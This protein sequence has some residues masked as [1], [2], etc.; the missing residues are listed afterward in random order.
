MQKCRDF[1]KECEGPFLRRPIWAVISAE[2]PPRSP[3]PPKKNPMEFHERKS[4]LAPQLM[5]KPCVK[6]MLEPHS[7][8]KF[9]CTVHTSS[10]RREIQVDSAARPA[11]SSGSWGSG[12]KTRQLRRRGALLLSHSNFLLISPLL[13]YVKSFSR[14]TSAFLSRCRV[15]T[16]S[17]LWACYCLLDCRMDIKC[18]RRPTSTLL[19]Y[20]LAVSSAS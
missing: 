1:A 8:L 14:A 13:N 5:P 9:V 18:L 11:L 20:E 6:S 19:L 3:L 17:L 15:A 2:A 16:P 7:L 4:F 10:L 12:G